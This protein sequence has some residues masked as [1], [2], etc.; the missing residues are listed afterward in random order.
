[1]PLSCR[2]CCPG[3]L[4]AAPAGREGGRQGEHPTD[5]P[6]CQTPSPLVS[7]RQHQHV[8]T[9]LLSHFSCPRRKQLSHLSEEMAKP[10][11]QNKP[12]AQSLV[13]CAKLQPK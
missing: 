9:A 13:V 10:D 2:Q 11:Q 3:M 7:G 5:P 1:M 6:P 4:C 12:L 8:G